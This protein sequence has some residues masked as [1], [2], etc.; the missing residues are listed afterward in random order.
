MSGARWDRPELH[1]LLDQLRHGDVLVVRKLDRLDLLPVLSAAPSRLHIVTPTEVRA[2]RRGSSYRRASRLPRELLGAPSRDR[3]RESP[4]QNAGA[5]CYPR[6][7]SST[8]ADS[9]CTLLRTYA[10]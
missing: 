2:P 4:Q 1:R 8:R 9:N 3:A 5:S 10:P 7:H 6:S